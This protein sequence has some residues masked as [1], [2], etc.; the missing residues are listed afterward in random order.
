M[1]IRITID[2][3]KLQKI[4]RPRTKIGML[5]VYLGRWLRDMVAFIPINPSYRYKGLKGLFTTVKPDEIGRTIRIEP[6]NIEKEFDNHMERL[7]LYDLLT[8]FLLTSFSALVVVLVT[9]LVAF[10]NIAPLKWFIPLSFNVISIPLGLIAVT[11]GIRITTLLVDGRFADSLVLLSTIYLMHDLQQ[12]DD[13]SNPDFRRAVLERIRILRRNVLLLSQTFAN[14]SSDK[15]K[16]SIEQLANIEEY[17]REREGWL[18]VSK[19]NTLSTLR[20]DFDKL[21]VILISGHYGEFKSSAKRKIKDIVATPLTFTDKLLQF[22]G[23]IFPYIVLLTLYFKPEYIKNIGLDTTTTFLV[24]V[25]WILLTIDVRLKLGFVE[26]IT[27]LA[28]T[29]KELR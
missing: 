16:A 10:L 18:I 9:I 22:I 11:L 3:T 15:N 26:R 14:T 25:A 29:M 17:I 1:T 19:K 23:I 8:S 12:N 7:R 13:L 20:K 2:E 27:G 21:A 24:A 4:R 6:A 5:I 28:K